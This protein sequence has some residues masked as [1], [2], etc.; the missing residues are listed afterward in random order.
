[1]RAL[2]NPVLLV[3]CQRAVVSSNACTDVMYGDQY[4]LF[5]IPFYLVEVTYWPPVVHGTFK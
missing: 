3:L 5:F 4:G 2:E 1:M